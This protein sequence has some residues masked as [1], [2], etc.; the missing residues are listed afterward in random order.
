M[1]SGNDPS[2][3]HPDVS[4]AVLVGGRSTRFGR[5]KAVAD[6]GGRPLALHAVLALRDAGIDPVIAVGGTAG[7]ALGLPTVADRH[8]GQG[9]LGGLITALRWAGRGLVVVVPCDLPLL[10]AAHV[11]SLVAAAGP[12]RA[13]VAEVEGRPQPSVACW[14][15]S[16]ARS[17]QQH[18]DDG[19]RAWR[20]ALSAGEWRPVPMA[21]EAVADAD[22]PEA[23]DRLLAGDDGN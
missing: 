15:A 3:A 6:A 11:R 22:T 20:T 21:P 1:S 18:F 9:P 2:A 16:W 8:P 7:A 23:L 17:L 4:G 14:P 10:R 19:A 5:D 13:A 12:D